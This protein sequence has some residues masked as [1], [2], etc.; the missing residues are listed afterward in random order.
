MMGKK[1]RGERGGT[2]GKADEAL[3]G[4]NEGERERPSASRSLPSF[5]WFRS[6]TC[7]A[8]LHIAAA[9]CL[10]TLGLVSLTSCK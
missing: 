9:G 5:F 7:G 1:K 3:T 6:A 10:A 8:G 4:H 2:G